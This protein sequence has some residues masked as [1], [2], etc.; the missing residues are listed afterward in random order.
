M[1]TD[2]LA[3]AILRQFAGCLVSSGKI[4]GT[5]TDHKKCSVSEEDA[6]PAGDLCSK[7]IA[8]KSLHDKVQQSGD[9]SSEEAP[10]LDKVI[11]APE[12]G[13]GKQQEYIATSGETSSAKGPS[14]YGPDWQKIL[15]TI[16]NDNIS[17]FA[18]LLMADISIDGD[19]LYVD[20]PD[21]S[22]A[23]FKMLSL[24]R[25]LYV[26][27]DV[28]SEFTE[29]NMKFV[30]LRHCGEE[31]RGE[32]PENPS[33]KEIYESVDNGKM[34]QSSLFPPCESSPTE[35]PERVEDHEETSENDQTRLMPD[36]GFKEV[37]QEILNCTNGELM[38]IKSE[39]QQSYEDDVE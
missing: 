21:Q 22:S 26:L 13:S 18:A 19:N 25:N 10:P 36:R 9:K 5:A 17:I 27:Q 12:D 30:V 16:E 32:F 2:V 34:E 39:S 7:G 35:Q 14:S 4:D 1:R 24:D 38:M 6:E 33:N 37:V 29:G 20:F 3:G 23:A 11:A 31:K 8:E 28:I 15:Q